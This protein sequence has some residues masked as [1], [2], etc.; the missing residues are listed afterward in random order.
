[1][2]QVPPRLPNSSGGGL[3]PQ[4]V[5]DDER[6]VSIKALEPSLVADHVAGLRNEIE[7]ITSKYLRLAGAAN[8]APV[9][10]RRK[11]QFSRLG[12]ALGIVA[13]ELEGLSI[14]DEGDH[15]TAL[16]EHHLSHP[17]LDMDDVGKIDRF[18]YHTREYLGMARA[19]ENACEL[20]RREALSSA[21][22]GLQPAKIWNIW[23]REMARAWERHGL[24]DAVRN[25]GLGVSIFVRLIDI[26]QSALEPQ[27]RQHTTTLAA[28]S[29]AVLRALREGSGR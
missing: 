27:Y 29:Q 1:M 9:F 17:L 16:I 5:L 25:D 18:R 20:G 10:D 12:R 6:W 13:R 2:P 15:Y 14:G 24:S 28:L 22:A 3:P 7:T 26:V 4:F 8:S 21:Q 23:V 19:I 11:D